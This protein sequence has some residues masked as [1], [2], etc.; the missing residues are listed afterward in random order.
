MYQGDADGKGNEEG[1]V[2]VR[3]LRRHAQG[4]L[5]ACDGYGN[6]LLQARYPVRPPHS[7]EGGVRGNSSTPQVAASVMDGD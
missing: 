4:N 5:V 1:C 3:G 7:V 6:R 2:C